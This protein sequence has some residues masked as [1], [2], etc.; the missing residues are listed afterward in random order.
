MFE[1]QMQKLCWS[2]T[3]Y[4][5]EGTGPNANVLP[6]VPAAWSHKYHYTSLVTN[7]EYPDYNIL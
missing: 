3:I 1:M 7:Q 6:T 5:L 4:T 2:S